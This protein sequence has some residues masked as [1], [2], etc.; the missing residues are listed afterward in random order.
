[1]SQTLQG[2]QPA[3]TPPSP[4]AVPVV[5]RIGAGERGADSPGRLMT[6]VAVGFLLASPVI[7]LLVWLN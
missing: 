6:M 7:T 3:A 5:R 2:I 1:M 4:F